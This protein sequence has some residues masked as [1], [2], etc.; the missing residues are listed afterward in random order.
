[1]IS[2]RKQWMQ[3]LLVTIIACLCFSCTPSVSASTNDVINKLYKQ[4]GETKQI[5]TLIRNYCDVVLNSPGFVQN[6]FPYNAQQSAFVHLIC[7]NI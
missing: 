1:M 7:K 3:L 4:S 2:R 5:R 6:N